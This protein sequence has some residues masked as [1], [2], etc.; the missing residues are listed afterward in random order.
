[1][2]ELIETEELQRLARRQL[3]DYYART[4]GRMFAGG[5]HRLDLDAAYR[6]QLEIARL[7]TEVH[8]E[9]VMGYKIGCVSPSV[10]RQLGVE[11]PVFGHVFASEG[12][13]DGASLSPA[14]FCRLGIEGEFAVTLAADIAE[15][16]VL[17]DRPERFV[18]R[19]FPVIELHNHMLRGTEPSAVEVVAN[20]ALHAGIVLPERK[21]PP[22]GGQT[23][24]IQVWINDERQ[25]RATVDPL[26]TLPALA[27][28]LAVQGI[29][30][31]QGDL[32]LTGSPLPIYDVGPG[33]AI[34]VEA[35][36]IGTVRAF[37]GD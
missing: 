11:H 7:R 37:V 10:Q 26:A 22:T 15:P 12:W 32:A 20:N 4:P 13:L 3:A 9:A 8:G 2:P 23:L 25:G 29:H 6:L 35:P 17:R 1:M 18:E 16:A 21:V 30:L 36:Q 19:V 24:E 27:E 33:D 14:A 31:R 5:S 28:R 34:R